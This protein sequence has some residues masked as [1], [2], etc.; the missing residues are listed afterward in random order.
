MSELSREE[1]TSIGRRSTKTLSRWWEELNCW[2]WPKEL[3]PEEG[4]DVPNRPRRSALM[5]R[6]EQVVAFR[7]MKQFWS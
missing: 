6:I 4:R 2:R 1:Y 3:P 7:A 5:R